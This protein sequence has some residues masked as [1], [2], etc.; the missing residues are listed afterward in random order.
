M[1]KVTIESSFNRDQELKKY[2]EEGDGSE[3]SLRRV[4]DE[5]RRWFTVPNE[6]R[7]FFKVGRGGHHV[8][9]SDHLGVR[10][11]IIKEERE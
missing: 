2:Y 7:K 6:R 5:L 3:N 8:W 10:M 11:M 4:E 9:L 1:L